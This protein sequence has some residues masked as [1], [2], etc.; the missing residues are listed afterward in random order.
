MHFAELPETGIQVSQIAMGCWAIAGD[1]TWG[2]QDERDAI[3]AVHASLDQGINFFD[4]AEL[5]GGGLSEQRL[6]KA[7]AGRRD[8]AVIASKFN[9][10]NAAH[11]QLIDACNRSLGYLAT[12]YL[13]LYQV[14]FA[15]RDVPFEETHAALES[16]Q[17]Q[18]KIRAFGVCNFG[19]GDLDAQLKLG[20]PATN[21]LPYSLLFRAIEYEIV[22]RCLDHQIGILCYSPLLLGLL[23]GK[24]ATA[25]DVPEGR[26]RTRHF[27]GDRPQARHGEPGCEAE[28]F[29][30]LT[31]IRRIA[32][33]LGQSMTDVALAWLLHQPG[34][35]SVLCGIRNASQ[36]TS[37]VAATELSL[38][39]SALADL[40]AA[41]AA[42]KQALGKNPDMW[43][44][45][46]DS[47]YR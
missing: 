11:D 6:G 4:T 26:A 45:A 12:D 33:G 15:S 21:Q 23:T 17:Q 32:D 10:A 47:R 38:D 37:N 42:L 43:Q 29:A 2:E 28:T 30:A 7:L 18:G 19:P 8:Q 14:H 44:P 46:H 3:R 27:S 16:L 36:A 1:R 5:Y 22:P 20:K 39:E 25:D 31:E 13:D 34:V 41:T 35:T 24:F 9:P 40:D